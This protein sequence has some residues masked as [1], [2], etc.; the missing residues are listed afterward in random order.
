MRRALVTGGSGYFGSV[1][2][3]ELAANGYTVR[4]LDLNAPEPG[5]VTLEHIGGDIRDYD[6]IRG[7]CADVDVVF[8]N[9][10]QQ[11]L[12]RDK[13]LIESV[14]V[15]GTGNMLRAAADAGVAKVVFTSSSAVFGA[16]T[17]SPVTESTPTAPAELYGQ[18]KARAETLCAEAVANG[19]DVSIIRPR[20]VL[21]H[22][23]LG[24]FGILFDWVA[25]GA[26]VFVFGKGDNRYQFVHA[27]DLAAACRLA[28]EQSGP[29]TYNIGAA[30]FGTM[31][32]TLQALVDHAGTG[33]AVRSLP[34]RPASMAMS[35]LSRVGLAPF[36]P[37]HWL[38]YGKELWFDITKAEAD[39]G[40]A[41]RYSNAAMM[42]ESYEWFLAHRAQTDDPTRSLHQRSSRQGALRVLKRVA[43][44]L[45]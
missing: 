42:I 22:G 3:A 29:G 23:R 8:H 36:G 27:N 15:G 33:S 25:D 34:I 2:V 39:L 12:A 32:E 38:V 45:A 4:N 13:D 35:V 21:G 44:A 7:A 10:A 37:Y 9:V 30:E 17:K 6:T 20:T 43:R 16:T 24:I 40:W 18:A 14:N 41:P 26:A 11:P 31:R 28:G 19:L 1:L 5:A